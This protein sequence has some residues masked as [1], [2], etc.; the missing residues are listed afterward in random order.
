[1]N[2]GNRNLIANRPIDINNIGNNW[3]HRPEHRHGV[4][5]NNA[6]VQ[7]KFANNNLRA[8][9]GARQEFRG[10][11]D[12][13]PGGDRANLGNRERPG[14]GSPK[15]DRGDRPRAD[16]RQAGAGKRDGARQANRA[17]TGKSAARPAQRPSAAARP[18]GGP[19][20]DAAF[21]NI[22]RGRAAS[23]HSARGQASLAGGGFNRSFAGAGGGFRGGGASMGGGG[24]RGGGGGGFRGGGGGGGRRSDINAKHD[25]ALLGYLE[26]G[27]G[28]YRFSYVG[29]NRPYVGVMAQEVQR[30]MPHLVTRDTAGYLRVLYEGLGLKFQSYDQWIASGAPRLLP[31]AP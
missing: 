22:Q 30:R 23:I 29:E 18:S 9:S 6:A 19:R 8:G 12:G 21:D 2:W 10:K 31:E 5:Y 7:Q 13:R 27:L 24:F 20:R 11:T 1:M 25:V 26:N 16:A 15:A 17:G 4:R 28:F 14:A 3:Q